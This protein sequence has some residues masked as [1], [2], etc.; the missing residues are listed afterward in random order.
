M[1]Q[2]KFEEITKEWEEI[3]GKDGVFRMMTFKTFGQEKDTE[4]PE[5]QFDSAKARFIRAKLE[6]DMTFIEE[7][8]LQSVEYLSY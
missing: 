7:L 8:E 1:F 5:G 4:I 2:N 3:G 6:C